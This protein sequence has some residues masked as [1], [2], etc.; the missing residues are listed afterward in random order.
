MAGNTGAAG[1]T[2]TSR[3]LALLGAF[4]PEHRALTLTELAQR[5]DLP[6]ATAHRLV[7]ELTEWGALTRAQPQTRPS[8]TGGR[9]AG[10][11]TGNRTEHS[12]LILPLSETKSWCRVP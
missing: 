12:S 4:D 1:A 6:L 8:T 3:V 7:R 5:A 9:A 11:G 2:V 10:G